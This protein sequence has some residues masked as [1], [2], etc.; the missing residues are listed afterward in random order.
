MMYY[1]V[2]CYMLYVCV[3]VLVQVSICVCNLNVIGTEQI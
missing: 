1:C 3:Y 2:L